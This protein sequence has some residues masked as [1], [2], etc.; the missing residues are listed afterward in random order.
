MQEITLNNQRYLPVEV[1]EDKMLEQF[2]VSWYDGTH[3]VALKSRWIKQIPDGE[4][5]VIGVVAL[6]HTFMAKA[7]GIELEYATPEDF[8]DIQREINK[9][10]A[11][12]NLTDNTLLIKIIK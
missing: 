6:E 7:A 11:K 3:I 8:D 4:Y 9:Y 1:P 5:E 2:V 10:M 12:H